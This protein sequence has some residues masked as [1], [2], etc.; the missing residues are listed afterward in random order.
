MTNSFP[1][2]QSPARAFFHMQTA[3]RPEWFVSNPTDPPRITILRVTGWDNTP[4]YWLLPS[5]H[6]AAVYD[7]LRGTPVKV[8]T[9]NALPD[10]TNPGTGAS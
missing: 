5:E 10:W 8:K 2:A 7:T 4:T 9:V 6:V 1:E 3:I